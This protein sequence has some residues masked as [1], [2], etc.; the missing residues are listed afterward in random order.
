MEIGF[1]AFNIADSAICTG[2]GLVFLITLRNDR[3]AKPAPS[4]AA[5]P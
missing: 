1:P 4:E 5:K 2:V 3:Q